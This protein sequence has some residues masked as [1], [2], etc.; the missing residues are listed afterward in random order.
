MREKYRILVVDD[1]FINNIITEE[2]IKNTGLSEEIHIVTN[3]QEAIDFIKQHCLPA[4]SAA[5]ID[6]ILLDLNMPIMDGFEFLEKIQ[7]Y[8]LQQTVK[9]VVLT[10]STDNRDVDKANKYPIAGF[11][12]KPLTIEKFSQLYEKLTSS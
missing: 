2:I 12:S 5:C 3:G 4:D 11:L 1:D 9:I 6:L 8:P 7:Q 10:T